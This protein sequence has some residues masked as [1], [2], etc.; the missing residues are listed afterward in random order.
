MRFN[1]AVSEVRKNQP[2]LR[3]PT[4]AKLSTM[5]TEQ[6]GKPV[7]F[8]TAVRS[9]A[10]VLHGIDGFFEIVGEGTIVTIDLTLNSNKDACKADLLVCLDDVRNL[11]ALAARITG[12]FQT[13]MRRAAV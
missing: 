1:D 4:A 2:T 11:P 8:Y 7:R 3:T 9:C 13:K 12:K 10:D 5:V 6:L